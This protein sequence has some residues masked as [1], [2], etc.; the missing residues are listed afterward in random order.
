MKFLVENSRYLAIVA[1]YG[2]LIGAV[3]A[4]FLGVVKTVE[5]VSTTYADYHHAEPSFYILFEALDCFLVASALIVIAVS[6]YEL[7]IGILEVPDWMLVKDLTELKAKFTFVIIPVMAVKFVQKI[8][9]AENALDTLYYG[10]AIA[11]VAAALTVFN[12][13][14]VKEKEAKKIEKELDDG[15]ET[16]A[17][18]LKK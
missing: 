11:V 3:A 7:F 18:D 8:L 9:K 6:L 15:S 10:L 16:R 4:L 5:L 17:E 14:S 1:V 13:I 2:M 12:L